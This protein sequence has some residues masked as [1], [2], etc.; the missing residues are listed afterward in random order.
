MLFNNDIKTL[1]YWLLSTE[2]LK[3][4]GHFANI[5]LNMHYKSAKA[6]DHGWMILSLANCSNIED[7]SWIVPSHVRE[8][9]FFGS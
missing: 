4:K 7:I 5:L 6:V 2:L 9:K 3:K 8:M 1:V